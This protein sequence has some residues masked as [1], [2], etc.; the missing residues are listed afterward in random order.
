[1]SSFL[2]YPF[3]FLKT[4]IQFQGTGVGF[5]GHVWQFQGYN[6]FL[7]MRQ[8]HSTGAGFSGIFEGFDAH[9]Y[10][11]LSYLAVRNTVYSL[12]YNQVKP[13][14]PY[15]DLSYREKSLIASLAGALGAIVSHPFTVVSIRQILD[16]QINKEFRRNYSPSVL[17]AVGQLRAS[18]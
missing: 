8:V 16:G 13:V 1:V 6:P 2:T 15:N 17:E 11:R 14:K 10:G 3:E 9:L 7:I 4:V 18:G 5:R 12:I